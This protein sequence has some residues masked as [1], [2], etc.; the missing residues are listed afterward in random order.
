MNKR[1]FKFRGK[2]VFTDT[3]KY[4]DLVHNQKV[5]T[6]GLEPRTMVGGYEV[7]EETVSQYTGINDC[8]GK[9]IYEGDILRYIDDNKVKKKYD[10]VVVFYDGSYFLRNIKTGM[11]TLLLIFCIDKELSKWK[12]I[13]NIFDN[14]L[15]GKGKNE[16]N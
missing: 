11:D 15:E 12:I 10:R 5:T 9:E 16:T 1:I 7:K 13:G 2:D 3:W 14:N 8:D 6:T 4:G